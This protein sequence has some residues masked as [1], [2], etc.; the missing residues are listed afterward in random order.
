MRLKIG[1]S[2]AII[3]MVAIHDGHQLLLYWFYIVHNNNR[4][5]RSRNTANYMKLLIA[6]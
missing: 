5:R 2:A 6:I 4:N 3:K 1:G